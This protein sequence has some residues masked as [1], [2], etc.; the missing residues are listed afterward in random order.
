MDL[1][2]VL[3]NSKVSRID[4]RFDLIQRVLERF[5]L[6]SMHLTVSECLPQTAPLLQHTTE[7]YYN[8][9]AAAMETDVLLLQVCR[10]CNK[11]SAHLWQTDI[12]FEQFK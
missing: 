12:N 10:L 4:G 1:N 8:G 9:P 6:K 7:Y 11:L 3:K 5:E 2:A